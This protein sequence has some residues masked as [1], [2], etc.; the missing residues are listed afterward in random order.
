[1][2][3]WRIALIAVLAAASILAIALH[4]RVPQDPRYH[5]FADQRTVFGVPNWWNV[6][7]SAA[8][9]LAGLAGL[10]ALRRSP[11]GML[12]DLY[13]AYLLFFVGAMLTG[14]GS[15]AYHLRPDNVTLAY[16]RLPMTLLFMAF[17][18]IIIGEHFG[19][20]IGRAALPFLVI[21]GFASIA[22]WEATEASG[23][24]DLR[25]YAVVQFV[26]MVLIPAVLLL[27]PS[28]LAGTA[29]V[30]ATVALYGVAKA[31]ELLDAQMYR[32][33]ISGHTLKHLAAAAAVLVMAAA[34]RRRR[35]SLAAAADS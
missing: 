19:A 35:P 34:M 29:F 5:E 27:F 12:R 4:A 17:A 20:R 3:R 28:L 33:G 1:M 16:D 11:Q 6:A 26:P 10:I 15:A 32:I 9:L 31:F 22:Y 30:W 23:R 8:L 21:A 7:S 18:A 2:H 25:P 24:G 13:P 14:I